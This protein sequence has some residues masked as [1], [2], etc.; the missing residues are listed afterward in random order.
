DHSS[1]S[2]TIYIGNADGTFQ[3]PKVYETG[4][5]PYAITLDYFDNDEILDLAVAH[6][7]DPGR[8]T[9]HRGDGQGGFTLQDEFEVSG[10]L[11]YIAS[12][13]ID[14]EGSKDILV[15]RNEGDYASLFL[16][17][18]NGR[19]HGPEIKLQ[20]QNRIYSSLV[21]DLNSDAY[22]DFVSVDYS[23]NTLAI[24]LGKE[25]SVEDTE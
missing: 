12:A 14:A 13:D 16:N 19:F 6:S 3:E 21:A 7:T 1:G 8:V 24:A 15:T 4:D 9:I 20:A 25:P 5:L 23:N 18:G 22:P 2:S 17:D 11:I 10:R